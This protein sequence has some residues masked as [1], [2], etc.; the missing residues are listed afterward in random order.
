[1]ENRSDKDEAMF[2]RYFET[3]ETIVNSDLVQDHDTC[4]QVDQTSDLQTSVSRKEL[5]TIFNV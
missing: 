4:K 5:M 2:M 3:P 1:M